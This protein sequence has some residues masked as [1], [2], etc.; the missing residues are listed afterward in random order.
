MPLGGDVMKKAW[1]LIL[2]MV[3][4]S[5]LCVGLLCGCKVV[6]LKYLNEIDELEV[7]ALGRD[8]VGVTIS[9]SVNVDYGGT[10]S[11]DSEE[12][13]LRWFKTQY[14]DHCIVWDVPTEE[15]GARTTYYYFGRRVYNFVDFAGERRL[16]KETVREGTQPLSVEQVFNGDFA[17]FDSFPEGCEPP[18]F[19][20]AFLW[21]KIN[22]V[23]EAALVIKKA[24]EGELTRYTYEVHGYK[25]VIDAFT[26]GQF[27]EMLN[28]AEI[29]LPDILAINIEAKDGQLL[30]ESMEFSFKVSDITVTMAMAMDFRYEVDTT[31][32]IEIKQDYEVATLRRDILREIV[33]ADPDQHAA[34]VEDYP[35]SVEGR[36][37]CYDLC[38]DSDRYTWMFSDGADYVVG[39]MGNC[40]QLDVFDAHTLDKLYTM[41]FRERVD[42]SILCADGKLCVAYVLDEWCTNVYSLE[43]GA[44]LATYGATHQRVILGNKLYVIRET[45]LPNYSLMPNLYVVDGAHD[46]YLVEEIDLSARSERVLQRCARV[47]Y[48]LGDHAIMTYI[49][50]QN[51]VFFLYAVGRYWGYDVE[52]GRLLYAKEGQ[53]GGTSPHWTG[54]ALQGMDHKIIALTG[55][56][57]DYLM[58]DYSAYVLPKRYKYRNYIVANVDAHLGRF[59]VIDIVDER[60]RSDSGKHEHWIYD[61]TTDTLVMQCYGYT[62]KYVMLDETHFLKL[63]PS[64]EGRFVLKLN[65]DWYLEE[66]DD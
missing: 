30:R 45:R 20:D 58:P 51:K 38:G 13:D 56:I 10:S 40:Q 17:V 55:E 3:L 59:D 41:Y 64:A 14:G 62:H 43:D 21:L 18:A 36:V 65:V 27:T 26:D 19:E 33:P 9:T 1:I 6:G 37:E 54:D 25:E 60:Y 42:A 32:P 39:V 15:S 7:Q 28:E 66:A 4:L 23:E 44:L 61:T 52:S 8:N 57:S 12:M 35:L 16:A 46:D 31:I 29:E 11:F 53:V 2:G 22:S 34:L 47:E 50:E 48:P 49:D 63:N 5:A 24:D